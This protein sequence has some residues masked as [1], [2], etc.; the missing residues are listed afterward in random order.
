MVDERVERFYQVGRERWPHLPDCREALADLI[1]DTSALEHAADLYLAAACATGDADA[2][3]AFHEHYDGP[4]RGIIGALGL[5]DDIR[6]EARQRLVTRLFVASETSG[7]RIC[8]YHGRGS[9]LSF[10]RV[11]AIRQAQELVRRRHHRVEVSDDALGN[12]PSATTDPELA[13]LKRLYQHEFARAFRAAIATLAP[14]DRTLLRY[15][16][17]DGLN[18]DRLAE[19]YGVHRATAAR[20]VAAA[21]A[22]LVDATQD[23]LRSALA[24]DLETLDSIMRLVESNADVSARRL[25]AAEP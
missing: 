21:R 14:R 24:V 5:S 1:N 3:R 10:V 18:I 12:A 20:Q 2:L 22:A 25:L 7:P 11:A 19:M 16:L 9:L 23:E 6:Q 15:S 8:G 13:Y 17:V 4:L